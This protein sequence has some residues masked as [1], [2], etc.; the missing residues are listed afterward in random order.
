MSL[1]LFI[2]RAVLRCINF[3]LDV[4]LGDEGSVLFQ[5]RLLNFD[6]GE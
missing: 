4:D 2:S 1:H 5:L 6:I 3:R